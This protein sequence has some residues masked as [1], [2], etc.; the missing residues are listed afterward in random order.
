MNFAYNGERIAFSFRFSVKGK[1][2][3]PKSMRQMMTI[4][5]RDALDNDHIEEIP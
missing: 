3:F 2:T 4:Q 1:P 5:L